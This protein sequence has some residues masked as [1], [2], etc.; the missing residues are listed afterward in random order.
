MTGE[1]KGGPV[2]GSRAHPDVEKEVLRRL[3][4]WRRELLEIME[5]TK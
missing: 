5:R 4:R 3:P 2:K 1:E